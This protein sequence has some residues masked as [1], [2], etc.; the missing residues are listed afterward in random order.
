MQKFEDVAVDS[1]Q[2]S[3]ILREVKLCAESNCAELDSAQYDTARS[4]VPCSIILRV[5][6]VLNCVV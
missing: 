6:L 1:V 5:A 3:M 4:Q 2:Y